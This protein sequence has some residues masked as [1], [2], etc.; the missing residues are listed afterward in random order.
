VTVTRIAEW[1]CLK[2]GRD[3][4]T[5]RPE[6]D[7]ELYFGR[8]KLEENLRAQLL[9]GL[10]VA[11]VPRMVIFGPYGSGKTHTLHHIKWYLENVD[12]PVMSQVRIVKMPLLARNSTFLALHAKLVDAV[13]LEYVRTVL[14]LFMTSRA[15]SWIDDL[16]ATVGDPNVAQGLRGLLL[17]GT[18]Q[19]TAWRWLMGE[20]IGDTD[21]ANLQITRAY[22][23]AEDLVKILQSLGSLIRS[24]SDQRLVFLIDEA[25]LLDGIRAPE[26][27]D[28]FKESMRLLS[29]EAS[30][31]VGFVV[32]SLRPIEDENASFQILAGGAV[33]TRL[34]EKNYVQIPQME[35]VIAAEFVRDLLKELVDPTC[36]EARAVTE[37]DLFPFSTSA[38]ELLDQWMTEDPTRQ[39][40]RPIIQALNNG[41][42][43]A[44]ES[45]KDHVDGPAMARALGL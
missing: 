18:M 28:S 27:V 7:A 29:E 6:I 15:A 30:S 45:G 5:V 9:Y 26:A 13:G 38:I 11:G 33:A 4:F 36:V 12:L 31:D 23:G 41:A 14:N 19:L 24:V 32:A 42:F 43:A 10:S 17:G 35:P 2:A 16:A 21:Q 44:W 25:E 1:A 3:N 39:L 20:K 22:T 34:G 8:A 37:P 40:P